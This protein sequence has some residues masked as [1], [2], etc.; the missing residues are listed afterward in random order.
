MKKLVKAL[1]HIKNGVPK[2][3]VPA[4]NRALDKGRTEIRREVRKIYIIKA[5]DIP[6]TKTGANKGSLGGSLMVRD[7]MMFLDRFFT[8]GGVKRKPLFARVKIGGGGV[9]AHGFKW[10]MRAYRRVGAERLPIRRLY[11]IS[12]PIMVSQPHI[13][14]IVNK[15]MG[16]ML[17]K[18][19]AHEFIR[20]MSAAGGHS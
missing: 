10:S 20:V 7:T 4:I 19:L 15:A 14:P 17:D 6:I 11:S 18:R 9:I 13:A 1:D 2:V 3:V 16:D 12:A 8:S 5:K